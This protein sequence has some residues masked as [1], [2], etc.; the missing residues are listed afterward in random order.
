[1]VLLI[2]LRVDWLVEE[3]MYI[4]LVLI[5]NKHNLYERDFVFAHYEEWSR[6]K[7]LSV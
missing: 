3:F 1:M 6:V 2:V 7:S 4:S 5:L